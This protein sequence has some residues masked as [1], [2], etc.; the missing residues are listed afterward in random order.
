MNSDSNVLRSG[1]VTV[2][3]IAA[4]VM[5]LVGCSQFKDLVKKEQRQ[6]D[7]EEVVQVRNMDG[8]LSTSAVAGYAPTMKLWSDGDEARIVNG[9]ATNI[10]LSGF[11]ADKEVIIT[12]VDPGR[13][14]V[15]MRV[16]RKK[17]A[18][19]R[20]TSKCQVFTIGNTDV[21]PPIEIA[22]GLQPQQVVVTP[23]CDGVNSVIGYEIRY[24]STEAG[25]RSAARNGMKKFKLCSERRRVPISNPC[26]Y[27]GVGC[28]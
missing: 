26:R 13:N 22:D 25:C 21:L 15:V 10:D 19:I 17:T 16:A 20:F 5:G 1:F 7:N 24:G 28:D 18:E 23:L 6:P 14:E 2:V 3:A 8:D 12:E 9:S 27:F 11:D 4:T